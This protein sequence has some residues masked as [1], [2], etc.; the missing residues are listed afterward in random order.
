MSESS[1]E[2]VGA[3]LRK[4]WAGEYCAR[5]YVL[6]TLRMSNEAYRRLDPTLPVNL[7]QEADE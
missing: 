3:E 7:N 6:V 5:T 2:I 4:E 1:A